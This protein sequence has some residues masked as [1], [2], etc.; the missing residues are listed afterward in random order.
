MF[1][2]GSDRKEFFFNLV[3]GLC[4]DELLVEWHTLEIKRL[5]CGC[6]KAPPP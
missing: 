2:G 3:A 4:G 6:E 5:V 1:D